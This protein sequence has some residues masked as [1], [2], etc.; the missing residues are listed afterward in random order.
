M[1]GNALPLSYTPGLILAF[2]RISCSETFYAF[3]P[4]GLDFKFG[5]EP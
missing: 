5:L 4:V 3:V 2:L 1:L